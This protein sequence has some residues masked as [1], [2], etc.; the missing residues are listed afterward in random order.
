MT[1]DKII[2]LVNEPISIQ[3]TRKKNLYIYMYFQKILVV[4]LTRLP[5]SLWCLTSMQLDVCIISPV[6]YH[7][8][9]HLPDPDQRFT[10][11][12]KVNDLHMIE[13]YIQILWL[14]VTPSPPLKKKNTTKKILLVIS[15]HEADDT[16]N[17]MFKDI[18]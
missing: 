6:S 3:H 15:I 16:L 8:P 10:E 9:K 5:L 4:M 14:L 1:T 13:Q 2:S 18:I 12:R 17:F 7:F 11:H